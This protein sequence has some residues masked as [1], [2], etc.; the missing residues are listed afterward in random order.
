MPFEP[1]ETQEQL[2]NIIT[3]RLK[4]ETEKYK[5]WLSPE[6][7]E[8]ALNAEIEK[9]TAANTALEAAKNELSAANAK[10]HGYE[11]ASVKTKIAGEFGIPAALS[12]RLS[13]D[14]EAAIRADAEALKSALGNINTAPGRSTEPADNAKTDD[15]RSALA[16]LV[17]GLNN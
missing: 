9:T 12:G 5:N 13:G 6:A 8:A 11:I 3:A 4:R 10:I 7:H 14:D 1:I 2:D 17:Q 15:T 16:E